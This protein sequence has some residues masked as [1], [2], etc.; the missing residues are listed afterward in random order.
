MKVGKQRMVESMLVV[1]PQ[2]CTF[3][4]QG[5]VG[6][7]TEVDCM[8]ILEVFAVDRASVSLLG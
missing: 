6:I 8:N 1:G 7:K 4:N 5:K 3:P 2:K